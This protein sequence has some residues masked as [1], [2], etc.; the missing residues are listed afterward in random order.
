MIHAFLPSFVE[1]RKAEVTKTMRGIHHRKKWY[2]APFSGPPW[3]DSA[4]NFIGSLFPQT[5]R[6]AKFRPNPS[7]LR[8]DYAEK[9]MSFRITTI[10]A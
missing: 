8:G 10:L 4:E 5:H 9:L 3:S 2:F 7:S 1:I 6:S